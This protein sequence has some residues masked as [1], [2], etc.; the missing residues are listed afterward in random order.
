MSSKD[1]AAFSRVKF[2]PANRRV[3]YG[4]ALGLLAACLGNGMAQAQAQIPLPGNGDGEIPV[5]LS[6]D[7]IVHDRDLNIVTAKGNVEISQDDRTL[8]ADMVSYNLNQDVIT[9][10]GNVSLLDP[11]GD[12]TFVDYFELTG[13]LKTG[14]ARDVRMLLSDNSR[15]AAL[16]GRRVSG[17]R[18]ELDK[19][20][21]SPC[22]PCKDNPDRAPLWQLKAQ[23]VT[24]DTVAKEVEYRDAWLEMFGLPVLYTPYLSHPDPTV[25]RRSGV[26]VP[27]VGFSNSLGASLRTPYF[28][29]LSDHEDVTVTPM[30]IEKDNPALAAEHRRRF[31]KG[32]ILTQGSGTYTEDGEFRGHVL[33]NGRFHL[34]QNWRTGWE[35]ER[36][37][38]DT[39]QRRY[40]FSSSS[41]YLTT[42]P[43]VEGFGSR[44]YALAEGYAFQGLRE[45]DD[46]GETPLVLPHMAYSFAGQPN[47][48]GAYW[49][50]DAD[51]VSLTR[52]EGVSL[53]RVATNTEWSLPYTGGMGDIYTLRTSLRADS[54]VS[55]NPGDAEDGARARAVPQASLEW[56]WPWAKHHQASHQ[57]VEPVVV[58]IVSPRGGNPEIIPNEDSQF[59]EFD[60]TNLFSTNRFVGYDRIETGPRVNYGLRWGWYGDSGRSV[61]AVLGQSYRLFRDSDLAGDT[62]LSKNLSDYVGRL[63][64]NLAPNLDLLYRFRLDRDGYEARRQEIGARIGPNALRF[65]ADYILL[66]QEKGQT[67][68]GDRH[69]LR[70]GVSS[71]ISQYWSVNASN[72]YDLTDGGGSLI[73]SLGFTYADECFVFSGVLQDTN[74]SDRDYEGGTSVMFTLGFKNL[75]ELPLNVF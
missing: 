50:F 33:G 23:R 13:D 7:E 42:R 75:G 4:T 68:F 40:G 5:L 2:P 18:N 21:Y 65:L 11:S 41:S 56:R 28:G 3:A 74:T 70:S 29:V 26:L 35:L 51:L 67:E 27:T 6:A 43:Y 39:Y 31:R 15:I 14:V 32:E 61:S 30:A 45:T 17:T 54:Y 46:P 20:V 48:Q 57:V 66:D 55:D 16:A 1:G 34:N 22:E 37:T 19:A 38:D 62:G 12:V 25:K 53:H 10:T 52:D 59:F 8:L 69:Q 24:H 9:A 64:A 49:S 44:T 58:G 47:A 36:A 63:D 73:T 60:D 72:L 71:A